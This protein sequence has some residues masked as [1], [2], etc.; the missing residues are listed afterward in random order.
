VLAR[1]NGSS[2]EF[3]EA[4]VKLANEEP[5]PVKRGRKPKGLLVESAFEVDFN[6]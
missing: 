1:H 2:F 6:E 4:G 5:P 3:T